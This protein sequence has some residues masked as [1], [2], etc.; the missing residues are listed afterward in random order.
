MKTSNILL[1]DQLS[2]RARSLAISAEISFQEA[3]PLAN[4][5]RD[6]SPESIRPFVQV[7]DLGLC[8][9]L[10]PLETHARTRRMGT[11]GYIDP[12]CVPV[13]PNPAP[14]GVPLP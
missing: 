8:R 9:R 2:P 6:E 7:S 1:D 14:L 10:A 3:R 11:D 13:S 12:E 5:P 4:T